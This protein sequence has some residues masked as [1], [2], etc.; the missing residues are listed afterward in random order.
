MPM[1]HLH[2]SRSY[3][4]ANS[5]VARFFVIELP[6]HL[7]EELLAPLTIH[8]NSIPVHW[9]SCDQGRFQA[10]TVVA[11]YCL[12]AVLDTQSCCPFH[13]AQHLSVP[14]RT[15]ICPG[16]GSRHRCAMIGRHSD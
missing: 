7:I 14:Q 16:H 5:S 6:E 15:N 10:T 2:F 9:M 13:K 3:F 8:A 12:R 1:D 4:D 11:R